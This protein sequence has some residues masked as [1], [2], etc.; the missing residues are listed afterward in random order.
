MSVVENLLDRLDQS[1]ERLLVA[2]E[3]LPD[4]ALLQPQA[5]GRFSVADVLVNLTVWEAELVTAL[6]RIDQGKKPGNLLAALA[7]RDAFNEKRFQE[8]RDRDLD[9][10]FDDLQQVR[11]AL[12]GWLEHFSERDLANPKRYAWL[13]GKSLA[14][15]IE[16]VAVANEQRYRPR[17]ITFAQQ[18]AQRTADLT[19]PL[20]A[21]DE[22]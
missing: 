22:E 19:L 17:V 8:N 11:I 1:R 3:P 9:R 4:E 2:L 5:I 12:E 18:W 6:M 21:T 7:N 15:L 16:E 14:R 10:I 20:T 13:Q